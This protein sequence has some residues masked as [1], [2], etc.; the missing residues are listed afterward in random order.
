MFKQVL[1]VILLGLALSV[2]A[3]AERPPNVV[4]LIGDD[5]GYP[6]FGFMGDQNVVTPNMDALAN[7]GITFTQA[8][9]T[10]SYCRPALR[11]LL[12]GLH[13]VRYSQRKNRIVEGW[14]KDVKG[15]DRKSDKEQR[16]WNAVANADA[17]KE[18]ETLPRLLGEKGYASW[19]GGKYGE[20][21]YKNGHFS[22]GMTDGWDMSKFD[23]DEFFYQLWGGDGYELGRTTME[24]MFDFIDRHQEQPFMI[25]YGPALPHVPLDAPYQHRKFYDNKGLSE[26]ARAY[27][28]NITWWDHGVG[29]LMDHIESR[30]LLDNTIFVYISDNGWEQEPQAEYK[31][32]PDAVYNDIK[33]A[34][35]GLIGKN[36]MH[37]FSYRSPVLFYWKDRIQTT[38]NTTSLVTSADIVPTILDLAGAR[39]PEGLD[40]R[41]LKPL[42]EGKPMQER[43]H[44]VGYN[45]K[46]RVPDYAFGKEEAAYYVRTHRW[47][48]IW[49]PE[50]EEMQLYDVTVDPFA[51]ND[52]IKNFPH[53][54]DGFLSNIEQWKKDV[55]MTGYVRID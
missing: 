24:P 5:H 4:L 39:I 43:T 32:D 29:Q 28:S 23:T 38:F 47:Q 31:S 6:Y 48:F 26:A 20:R 12:T 40:G 35:G 14:K 50:L 7:G 16:M 27:S 41:S 45:D 22:E 51:R 30:G 36:G 13:P 52:L 3:D 1:S 37:D 8:H 25:W 15:F 53:L 19:E 2:Q 11:T 46:R 10:A 33:Y 54:V 18:F 42:I 21:S 44:I 49:R 34:S 17:L 55:G 9:S